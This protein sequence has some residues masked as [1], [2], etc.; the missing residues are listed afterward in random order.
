MTDYSQIKEQMKLLKQQQLEVAKGFFSQYSMELFNKY[1]KLNSFGWKQYTLYFNDGD[2][3]NFGARTDIEQ[4][5]INGYRW[6]Y[7]D[8]D[9][10][11]ENPNYFLGYSETNWK[12]DSI[13]RKGIY[14]PNPFYNSDHKTLV[15]EIVLFLNQFEDDD[16]ESMFGDHKE[17]IVT[18][19]GVEVEEYTS[20]D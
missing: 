18:R 15:D 1:P 5:Y 6:E 13:E 11:T 20:H 14:S 8:G 12:Y 3:T 2:E 10:E 4:I 9:G 7:D 19:N 17:V 16:L